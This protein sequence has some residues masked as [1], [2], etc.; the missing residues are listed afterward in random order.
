MKPPR[1]PSAVPLI[2]LLIA[3]EADIVHARQRAR[4]V[5]VQ[6]RGSK[7][8]RVTRDDAGVK[9]IQPAR[10][11]VVPRA[12]GGDHVV[13]NAEVARFLE[14]A[15]R[16]LVHTDGAR[17]R[18][19]DLE[20][21]QCPG[22]APVGARYRVTGSFHLRERGEQLGR[23]GLRRMLSKDRRVA[24]PS[25]RRG[26]EERATDGEK[27]LRGLADNL[28]DPVSG[29]PDHRKNRQCSNDPDR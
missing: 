4:H 26:L 12:F 7:L 8:D 29:Q 1:P 3:S 28:V 21:L 9:I 25:L 10:V 18:S 20:R 24:A 23:N 2:S 17:R 14:R 16:H 15:V 6:I 13:M 19:V 27:Q 22:P 11:H 5:Y